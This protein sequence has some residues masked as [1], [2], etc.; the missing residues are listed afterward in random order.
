[1]HF[2]GVER[3]LSSWSEVIEPVPAVA[4][5]AKADFVVLQGAKSII[6]GSMNH[7][8]ETAADK[9]IL[10]LC[11]IVRYLP[12]DNDSNHQHKMKEKALVFHLGAQPMMSADLCVVR[13]SL[14]KTPIGPV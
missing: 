6:I 2:P 9:I 13:R 12:N 4:N 8:E 11:V 3:L 14:A 1:M 10:V 5:G 7:D